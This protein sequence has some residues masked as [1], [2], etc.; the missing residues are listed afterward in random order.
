M[1]TINIFTKYF[2]DPHRVPDQV[3]QRHFSRIKNSLFTAIKSGQFCPFLKQISSID[4]DRLYD[5]K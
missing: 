4:R 1:L 3:L 2:P 5:A